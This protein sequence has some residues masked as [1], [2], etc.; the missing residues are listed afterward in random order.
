MSWAVVDLGFGDAG[1]GLV[2]DA[3]VRRTGARVVIRAQGG[4]QAGH[5]V[6]APNGRHHT[7]AQLGASFVPGVRVL[8][9]PEVIVHPTALLREAQILGVEPAERVR[10]AGDALVITPYHQAANRVRERRRGSSRHGSCGVGVGETVLDARAWPLDAIR[11]RELG[12]PDALREKLLRVR[13]R[14]QEELGEVAGDEGE[15]LRRDE[16]L[17]RWIAAVGGVAAL[18]TDDPAAWVNGETSIFEGAQGVLLDEFAGFAPHVTHACT[19]FAP[20]ERLAAK[21][22]IRAR[23]LG[24]L[25]AHAVRHGAGPFPTEDPRIRPRSDHNAQ[26]EWQGAVRYGAF[27]A[28]LARYALDV[29]GPIDGLVLTHLDGPTDTWATGW[30]SDPAVSFESAAAA[31][32]ILAATSDLARDVSLLLQTPIFA[33]STGPR[34]SDMQ[35]APGR[36]VHEVEVP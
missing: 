26:N 17:D 25:R 21:L 34:A 32:P 11:A 22:G 15:I 7:F 36:C 2:T 31:R 30:E 10:I 18:V 29:T 1:K 24:V 20:A 23:R 5:N 14:K 28:V 33:T 19:T 3:L 35:W 8:L 27:D 9:G 4:A 12:D 13:A 16:V 6:V